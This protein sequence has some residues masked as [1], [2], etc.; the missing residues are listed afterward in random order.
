MP[1]YT[2][3]Y[4]KDTRHLTPMRNGVYLMAL[5]H[6]WDS[7]G[8][9]PLDEQECAG[10]CNCR[11]ADEIEALRY[12]IGRYFVRMDDGH[13]NKRITKE[14]ER[15]NAISDKR[16]GAAHARW[17]ARDQLKKLSDASAMQMHSKSN[18]SG[19][20]LSL[21]LSL[22]EPKTTNTPRKR[23]AA[24]RL[25]SVQDLIA[26]G[27]DEQSATDWLTNRKAKDLPLTPTAWKQA[28]AEAAKAGMSVAEAIRTAAGNGW[29]GFKASW[30]DNQKSVDRF[31]G[32]I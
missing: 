27:V 5:M 17:Q 12:V 3:D 30:V 1:L 4:I 20:S 10:I 6:C 32:A 8:P 19:P 16:A 22:E 28:K 31:A 15:W 23:G 24:A 21:S 18:A 13:Y 14:I 2:G 25:V 7:R 26:E 11:S 9:M 29:G